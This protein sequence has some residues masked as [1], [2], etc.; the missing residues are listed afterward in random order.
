MKCLLAA[1]LGR[2]ARGS[3][4]LAARNRVGAD[5]ERAVRF[6]LTKLTRRGWVV[7]AWWVGL[8]GAVLFFTNIFFFVGWVVMVLTSSQ[9]GYR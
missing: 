1:G 7:V 8:G 4:R 9:S 5:S 6:A 2:S 3:W